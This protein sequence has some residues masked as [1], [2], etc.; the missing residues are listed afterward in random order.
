MICGC[1]PATTQDHVPPKG[2]FKGLATQL[3]T[4]PACATCNNGSSSEDE[5]LR[6]Y[7][8]MQVGKQTPGSAALWDQGAHKSLKR[9][10]RLRT[11]VIA[12]AREIRLTDARGECVSRLAVEV[13]AQTY[14]TVFERTTRGLYFHH[15]GKILPPSVS[16]EVAPLEGVPDVSSEELRLLQQHAIA[17]EACVYRFGIAEEQPESSLW[18]YGFYGTFWIM[19]TTGDDTNTAL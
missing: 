3:I 2:L 9:K 17:G 13:P 16:V 18:L 19:A 6:F 5:D 14:Q 4:V 7:I 1:R 11:S 15:T 8:S 12:T 10:T